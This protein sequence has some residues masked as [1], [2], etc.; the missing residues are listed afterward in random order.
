MPLRCGPYHT[1]RP[2]LL[3][4]AAISL[5]PAFPAIG[6][7]DCRR[8]VS[9]GSREGE[10]KNTCTV[11]LSMPWTTRRM[12]REGERERERER[13]RETERERERERER[14]LRGPLQRDDEAQ[15]GKRPSGRRRTFFPP[16][17]LIAPLGKGDTSHNLNIYPEGTPLSLPRTHIH[18]HMYTHE[19]E[20][21]AR[22]GRRHPPGRTGQNMMVARVP[23]TSLGC[24]PRPCLAPHQHP[25]SASRAAGLITDLP[26]HP[27]TV[28][29]GL[30]SIDIWGGERG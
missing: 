11:C 10:K 12:V 7:Q 4:H 29:W 16:S 21:I 30:T 14:E 3:G 23:H 28:V 13:Q 2:L 25:G 22:T 5:S 24:S 8:G 27:C 15:A 18:V 1:P 26:A 19:R 17:L 6:L 20:W 9:P